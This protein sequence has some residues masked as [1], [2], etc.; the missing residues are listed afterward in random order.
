ML[1][2]RV[3]FVL[4]YRGGRHGAAL[5]PYGES[6]RQIVHPARAAPLFRE[7]EAITLLDLMA[8][9]RWEDFRT[10]NRANWDERVA[11]HL[12]SRFYG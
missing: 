1:T 11:V 7:R 5:T 6:L 3:A 4:I 8:N 12:G 2:E 9:D 10:A